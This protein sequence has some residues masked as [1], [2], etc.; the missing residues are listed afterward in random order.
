[1]LPGHGGFMD[2]FDSL[3]IAIPFVCVFLVLWK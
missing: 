1:M 2:R 3:L